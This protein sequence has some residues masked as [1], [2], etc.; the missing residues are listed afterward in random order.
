MKGILIIIG[1]CIGIAAYGQDVAF[2]NTAFR[3]DA[4]ASL[5]PVQENYLYSLQQHKTHCGAV[6]IGKVMMITGG[7]IVA[8]GGIMY[9]GRDK[10]IP[11]AE[12]LPDLTMLLGGTVVFYG[13]VIFG[14]GTLHDIEHKTRVS[15]IGKRNQFGLAY[16]F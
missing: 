1:L 15:V 13:A 4:Y 14:F 9:L 6:R 7:G 5:I 3:N 2:S 8:V 16:N 12:I 10:T 11:Y